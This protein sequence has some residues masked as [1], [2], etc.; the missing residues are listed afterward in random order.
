MNMHENSK[1]KAMLV[2][3]MVDEYYQPQSHVGCMRDIYRH[4]VVKI[5]PMSEPTFYRYMSYAI[6]VD[7][8][9]GNGSCRV[10][11]ERH[12]TQKNVSDNQLSLFD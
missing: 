3:R 10:E 8:Y 9:I 2:K 11:R 1:K 6:G 12:V 5:Y 7:G 4:K